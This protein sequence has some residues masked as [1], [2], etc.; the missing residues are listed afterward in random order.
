MQRTN[1]AGKE[2]DPKR[3]KTCKGNAIRS[4]SVVKMFINKNKNEKKSENVP[5]PACNTFVPLKS[6]N[7]HLDKYCGQEGQ[8][9]AITETRFKQ[10]K[11]KRENIIVIDDNC[12][13]DD[14]S[15]N[16]SKD[17]C[18]KSNY[19]NKNNTSPE[20]F[21]NFNVLIRSNIFRESEGM[22]KELLAFRKGLNPF[23]GKDVVAEGKAKNIE[24][25]SHS[26]TPDPHESHCNKS[27]MLFFDDSSMTSLGD[28]DKSATSYCSVDIC[29]LEPGTDSTSKTKIASQLQMKMFKDDLDVGVNQAQMT[30]SHSLKVSKSDN[31]LQ[32]EMAEKSFEP[33]YWENFNF[34][35]DSVLDETTSIELFSYEDTELIKKFKSTSQLAQQLYVRLFLR[36]HG[37]FKTDKI[38]YPKIGEDLKPMITELINTGMAN[39]LCF[40]LQ[41]I[42]GYNLKLEGCGQGTLFR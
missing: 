4:S 40:I 6:I 25:S 27:S 10:E 22:D 19:S 33:Y 14:K 30:D 26:E 31:D 35:V 21:E 12:D 13:D 5:C 7:E 34:V 29:K 18:K 39:F 41:I 36:K 17:S 37:W 23:R 1:N 20:N 11:R 2:R 15:H 8:E 3:K 38:K 9:T 24:S 16:K 32:A 28:C 42:H